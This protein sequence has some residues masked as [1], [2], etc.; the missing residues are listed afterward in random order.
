MGS[1]RRRRKQTGP[2]GCLGALLVI[3]GSMAFI[4]G[5]PVLGLFG[6]STFEPTRVALAATSCSGSRA[7]VWPLNGKITSD[8]GFRLVPDGEGSE[9]HTGVD[10]AADDGTPVQ[11]AASGT[12]TFAERSGNYGLLVK[13]K[14][15]GEDA[16]TWYGHLSAFAVHAGDRVQAGDTIG[17]V[18]STGRSTGPHLHFEYRVNG[19]P[20]DPRRLC[21]DQSTPGKV[22]TPQQFAQK[23]MP[24]A[25]LAADKLGVSRSYAPVFLTQWAHESGYESADWVG[26]RGAR[27]NYA[28][29]KGSGPFRSYPSIAAFV[30]DY[31]DVLRTTKVSSGLAY[32][33][34]IEL[35]RNGAPISQV[36]DALGASPWDQDH[37]GR[38]DGLPD[39]A[40]LHQRYRELA[41]WL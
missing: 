35:M 15:A 23:L 4:L 19:K 29:I 17:K 24:Y 22:L 2:P 11:A 9:N 20:I 30:D 6:I 16:E 28:G 33:R 18:G 5:T 37:Y 8:F 13:V 38:A 31:V 12:V 40:L 7:S 39:G 25:Q 34:V 41:P 36:F 27:N 26:R 14:H 21:L 1:G 10:I 3:G 32:G